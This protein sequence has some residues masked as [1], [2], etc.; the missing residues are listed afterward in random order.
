[1][2]CGVVA[3]AADKQ[4]ELAES[5]FTQHLA[6]DTEVSGIHGLRASRDPIASGQVRSVRI[7]VIGSL[8][9]VN[10]AGK[11]IAH[12]FRSQVDQCAASLGLQSLH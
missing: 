1:M 6:A 8:D 12:V 4:S 5:K 2:E 10:A 3:W 7:I 11:V 9:P